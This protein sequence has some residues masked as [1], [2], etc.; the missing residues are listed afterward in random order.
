MAGVEPASMDLFKGVVVHGGCSRPW[1]EGA[2][3]VL[4]ALAADAGAPA[5]TGGALD[6]SL[7]RLTWNEVG[8]NLGVRADSVSPSLCP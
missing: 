3:W 4:V 8:E 7:W 6:T 2:P 1:G 5:V